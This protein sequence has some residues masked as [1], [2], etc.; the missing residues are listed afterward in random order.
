MKKMP[1][2]SL[3]E[4]MGDRHENNLT[5]RCIGAICG[6]CCGG[7]KE[8]DMKAKYRGICWQAAPRDLAWMELGQRGQEG[9]LFS[10]SVVSD[11]L[12]PHGL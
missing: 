6:K 3:Q 5:S 9:M 8:G 11:S 7:R 2:W 4:I 10:R 12:Q 1:L